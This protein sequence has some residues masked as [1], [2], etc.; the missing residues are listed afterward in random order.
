[1]IAGCGN[2]ELSAHMWAD[3]FHSLLS[4][5]YSAVVVEQMRSLYANEPALAAQFEVGDVRDLRSLATCRS[6]GCFDAVVDKGTLDAILCGSDSNRNA[7]A[8]LA[9][10]HR[11]LAPASP[12]LGRGGGVLF[13]ITYGQP[14]S[15]LPL[16]E[17]KQFAWTVTHVPLGTTRFMYCC[18]RKG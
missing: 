8:M 5:D 4:V 16:L 2:S 13:V 3:G 6:D 17:R 14:S 9:E 7:T 15:R 11:L 12:S 1:L 10:M 18:R